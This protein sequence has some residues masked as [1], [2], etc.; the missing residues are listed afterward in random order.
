V[1]LNEAKTEKTELEAEF[2]TQKEMLKG[3]YKEELENCKQKHLEEVMSLEDVARVLRNEKQQLESFFEKEKIEIGQQFAAEKAEIEQV[4]ILQYFTIYTI[5][6]TG[7][8]GEAV[9]VI[10]ELEYMADCSQR[11]SVRAWNDVIVVV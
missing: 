7:K 5:L 2:H 8:A 1:I 10:P 6:V 11:C 4:C 3:L 9:L